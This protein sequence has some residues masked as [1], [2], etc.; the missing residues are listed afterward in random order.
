MISGL[1]KTHSASYS[2]NRLSRNFVITGRFL[3]IYKPPERNGIS[4][5]PFDPAT[6]ESEEGERE[7]WRI[8]NGMGHR[9]H[10]AQTQRRQEVGE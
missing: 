4:S 2:L 7:G 10:R 9:V 3:R 8:R 6:T 5:M 1:L